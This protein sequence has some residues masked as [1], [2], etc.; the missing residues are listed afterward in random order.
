MFGDC[1]L[2]RKYCDFF[3]NTLYKPKYSSFRM[4]YNMKRVLLNT[5]RVT[6]SDKT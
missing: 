3:E 4:P 6:A 5:L 2:F 1:V